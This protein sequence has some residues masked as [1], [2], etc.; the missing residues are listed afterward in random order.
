[1]DIQDKRIINTLTASVVLHILAYIMVIY[2]QL[3][4]KQIISMYG[5]A[6]LNNVGQINITLQLGYWT[7]VLMI[8]LFITGAAISGV[9][10]NMGPTGILSVGATLWIVFVILISDIPSFIESMMNA[11][12]GAEVLAGYSIVTRAVRSADK[13][14]IISYITMIGGIYT[15]KYRYAI[16]GGE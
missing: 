14:R 4:S 12:A 13:L 3:N 8:N 10:N 6:G 9:K 1:M 2:C 5:T 11:K 7:F 15:A 16:T